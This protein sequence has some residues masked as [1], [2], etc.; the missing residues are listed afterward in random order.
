MQKQF[1]LSNAGIPPQGFVNDGKKVM[2]SKTDGANQCGVKDCP[3]LAS[4]GT[5][6]K[7][8]SKFCTGL[9]GHTCL[10][11]GCTEEKVWHARL[12]PKCAGMT[13][14]DQ[15]ALN[16]GTMFAFTTKEEFLAVQ[17]YYDKEEVTMP[18][19]I[20][21]ETHDVPVPGAPPCIW[22]SKNCKCIC[23]ETAQPHCCATNPCSACCGGKFDPCGWVCCKASHTNK[24]GSKGTAHGVSRCGALI[25][26]CNGDDEGMFEALM[27][28][29]YYW[30]CVGCCGPSELK[31]MGPPDPN[32]KG[33]KKN[34]TEK[35]PGAPNR[36]Y[37]PQ[38]PG[39]C[40]YFQQQGWNAKD[41]VSL[42]YNSIVLRH[43]KEEKKWEKPIC[44]FMHC[45]KSPVYMCC[46]PCCICMQRKKALNGDMSNYRCFADRYCTLT[47]Y[48]CGP[49]KEGESKVNIDFALQKCESK[50]AL[51]LCCEVCCFCQQAALINHEMV[52]DE[53]AVETD[54]CE[55]KLVRLANFDQVWW[56]M[57]I[58][59][60]LACECTRGITEMIDG[61]GGDGGGGCLGE[62]TACLPCDPA[63]VIKELGGC[64]S[65]II[66]CNPADLCCCLDGCDLEKVRECMD[67]VQFLTDQVSGLSSC[68]HCCTFYLRMAQTDTQLSAIQSER[69]DGPKFAA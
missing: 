5:S 32:A 18:V 58:A 66:G 26:P 48:A 47:R 55:K 27:W 22:Y 35:D 13:R 54:V 63:C 17:E 16:R 68:A 6:S 60:D 34:V 8:K 7:D 44:D 30:A 41:R 49:W 50:P 28:F 62:V 10:K 21:G 4:S 39:D 40:C 42:V 12:C 64:L 53:S 20:K 57:K 33:K 51:G 1:L 38:Y 14:E 37:M 65:G 43:A 24:D 11:P 46:T 31:T 19:G 36:D 59:I 52:W 3:R 15:E 9:Y 2:G 69:V 25:N 29:P 56:C 67:C 61:G 23:T 45:I